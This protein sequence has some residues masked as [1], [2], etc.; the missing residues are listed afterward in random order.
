MAKVEMTIT[1][2]LT[3]L[4][5]IRGQLHRLSNEVAPLLLVIEPVSDLDREKIDQRARSFVDQLNA[6]EYNHFAIK[7]AINH[8]NAVTP[9]DIMINGDPMTITLAGALEFRRFAQERQHVTT[10]IV[11]HVRRTKREYQSKTEAAQAHAERSIPT[12]GGVSSEALNSLIS[13]FMPELY[14]PVGVEEL[15]GR[16]LRDNEFFVSQ[17]E[18]KI[19]EI[20]S[21]TRIVVDLYPPEG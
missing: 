20:N 10:A 5:T 11:D 13:A 12:T 1:E 2:G 8:A 19:T 9:I 18:G 15:V 3:R 7:A 14:D 21:S 17:L 4:R 6:L 16:R